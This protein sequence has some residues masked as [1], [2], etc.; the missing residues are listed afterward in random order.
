MAKTGIMPPSY[1]MVLT[2]YF[3]LLVPQHSETLSCSLS[4]PC[5]KLES[6]E[7]GQAESDS[8]GT[9]TGRRKEEQ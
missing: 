7:D 5:T 2:K 1:R 4:P 8:L 6:S 3:P 9:Q